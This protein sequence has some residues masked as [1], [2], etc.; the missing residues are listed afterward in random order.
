MS[1]WEA[2][3]S[4]SSTSPLEQKSG[5]SSLRVISFLRRRHKGTKRRRKRPERAEKRLQVAQ[6]SRSIKA[7]RNPPSPPSIPPHPPALHTQAAF[8]KPHPP[9]R[10]LLLSRSLKRERRMNGPLYYS[11][12]CAV[13]Q[14][15]RLH[16]AAFTAFINR[17][18]GLAAGGVG[19][20][21]GSMGWGGACKNCSAQQDA[22][23]DGGCITKICLE[24][25]A[26]RGPW[27][28]SQC[29]PPPPAFPLLPPSLTGHSHH[30]F[31]S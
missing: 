2:G 24:L 23:R 25:K 17:L 30:G 27:V 7:N 20:G 9:A 15:H 31:G 29:P 16:S 21:G 18:Q 8:P 22:G 4:L 12:P 5:H 6:I 28:G 1:G 14:Q 19:V 26:G 11:V 10:P 13:K 3:R